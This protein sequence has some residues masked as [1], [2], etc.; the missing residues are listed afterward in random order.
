[1]TEYFVQ[2]DNSPRPHVEKNHWAS[3]DNQRAFLDELAVQAFKVPP[4]ADLSHWYKINNKDLL[5]NGASG[6]LKR[7]NGSIVALLSTVYPEYTFQAWKF[8]STPKGWWDSKDNVNAFIEYLRNELQIEKGDFE[9]WY[10]LTADQLV[11]HGGGGGLLERYGGSISTLLADVFPDHDW[12]PWKF[13]K[14]PQNYWESLDNQKKFLDDV[15]K[16]IG[17]SSS[18]MEPWYQMTKEAFRKFGGGSLLTRYNNSVSKMLIAIYP[19]HNWKVW[20]FGKAQQGY[21]D[22]LEHQKLFLIDLASSLGFR[23]NDWEKWYEVSTEEFMKHGGGGLIKKYNS[24]VATLLAEVFPEREWLPWKFSKAPQQAFSKPE[25]LKQVIISVE[26]S[27]GISKRDDW[28]RVNR[29]QIEDMGLSHFVTKHGGMAAMLK[30]Y[31]PETAWDERYMFGKS[32][33]E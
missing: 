29:S 32:T 22:S 7:Y 19:H 31:Y 4:N 25:T 6:L 11:K 1:M 33:K 20:K 24:S 16:K 23:M 8:G 27:L 2:T 9:P 12:V 30:K 3:L 17:A 28:Y 15:A 26:K 18:N 13:S 10:N 14:A 21:W 5:K